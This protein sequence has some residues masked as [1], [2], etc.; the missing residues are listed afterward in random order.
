MKEVGRVKIN[1]ITEKDLAKVHYLIL[2]IQVLQNDLNKL[3]SK[4]LVKGQEINGMPFVDGISDRTGNI[5][6]SIVEI[7]ELIE[8]KL[9]EMYIQR[10]RIERFINDI[11]DAE[12]RLIIRLRSINNMKFR[13][14]GREVN[15]DSSTVFRKY[16]SFVSK[17]QKKQQDM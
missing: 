16:K 2:E 1:T 10:N 13:E 5:A 12:L 8:L 15:M 11:D 3:K 6:T 9:Q 4:S 14:I 17:L 7:E